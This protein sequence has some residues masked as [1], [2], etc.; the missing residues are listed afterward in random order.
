MRLGFIVDPLESLAPKKDSTVELMRSAADSGDSVF[1]VAHDGLV[2]SGELLLESR[3]LSVCRDDSRWFSAAPAELIPATEYDALLIRKEPPF[4]EEY[5][6]MT[7]LL[8]FAERSGVAVFNSPRSLRDFDEKLSVLQ[9]PELSPSTVVSRRSTPLHGFRERHGDVVIKPVGGMGG[10][11]VFCLLAGDRNFGA[12]VEAVGSAG[13]GTMVAQEYLPEARDGDRR[14]F[15]ID[16]EPAPQMLNRRPQQ[17]EHRANMAAGG[18]PEA[19]PL[20]EPERRIAAVVGPVLRDAGILVAGLD[21][22]GGKLTEINVTCPTGM[23]EIREQT[24]YDIASS[25]LSAVKA[26]VCA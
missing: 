3:Q 18:V 23:R 1:A 12:A 13:L 26:R 4:D 10:Q 14:V 5:L 8:E 6:R 20:G 21:V 25:V 7:L 16:G 9:F 22:I 24:G 19:L 17:G 2:H 15:V 11:G